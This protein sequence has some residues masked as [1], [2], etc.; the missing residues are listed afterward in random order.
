[1]AR[2]RE[3]LFREII[4]VDLEVLSPS[5]RLS[6][7]LLSLFF[8]SS[9]NGRAYILVLEVLEQL[10]LAVCALREDGCAEGLHDLLHGHRLAR[11]LVFCRTAMHFL[12][13][14]RRISRE[15]M[16]HFLPDEPEGTHA[17][18]LAVGGKGE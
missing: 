6:L 8:F 1:M 14:S 18:W 7:C 4:H 9:A 2:L 10:E 12:S 3:T 17:D 16:A 5:P 15:G 13:E 11:E